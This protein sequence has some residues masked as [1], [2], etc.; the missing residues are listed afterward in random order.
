MQIAEMKVFLV[1]DEPI[2]Q[3]MV[4]TLLTSLGVKTIDIVGTGS[5]AIKLAEKKAY[6]LY[7]IDIGLPDIDGF[8]VMQKICEL[9][10]KDANVFALTGHSEKEYKSKSLASGAKGVITKPLTKEKFLEIVT[11]LEKTDNKS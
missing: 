5:E 2:G 6:D 7:L 8:Q 4:E 9:Y 11:F 1:E 3:V 10:G